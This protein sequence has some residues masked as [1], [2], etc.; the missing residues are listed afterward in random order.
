M[1][2]PAAVVCVLQG[3]QGTP[4]SSLS[5][6]PPL[7]HEDGPPLSLDK[8]LCRSFQPG[9]L[10]S[11]YGIVCS[12]LLSCNLHFGQVHLLWPLQVHR[13]GGVSI[14]SIPA[15]ALVSTLWHRGGTAGHTASMDP[16]GCSLCPGP[17]YR[18][19]GWCGHPAGKPS[20]RDTQEPD[21]CRG[22]GQG[23]GRFQAQECRL[24]VDMVWS[25]IIV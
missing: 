2:Q 3:V 16:H 1:V 6:L 19:G 17:C 15:Q 11:V 8:Q 24:V 23:E 18:C 21:R 22:L 5:N 7:C 12:W 4:G 20:E 9:E 14:K 25:K 13:L 10:C